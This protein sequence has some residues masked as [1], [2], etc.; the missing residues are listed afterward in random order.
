MANVARIRASAA[1]TSRV[2]HTRAKDHPWSSDSHNGDHR[3][4]KYSNESSTY[5]LQKRSR[6]K[7]RQITGM[8]GFEKR[9]TRSEL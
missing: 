6:Q 1:A 5:K 8:S 9:H 7:G 4:P 3:H 2:E